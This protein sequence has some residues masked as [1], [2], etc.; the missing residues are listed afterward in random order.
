MGYDVQAIEPNKDAVEILRLKCDYHQLDKQKIFEARA[1]SLPFDGNYFDMVW[2]YT[3]L[4]HVQDIKKSIQEIYRVL[5]P[6]GWAFIATA[7][8]RH[9]YEPHYKIYLPNFLPVFLLKIILKLR[10]KPTQYIGKGINFITTRKVRNILQHMK[11]DSLLMHH[12]WPDEW[13]NHRNFNMH[14]TYW[15]YR[16]TGIPRDQWWFVRKRTD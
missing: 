11:F 2:S 9:F 10:G 4:E 1:E 3:V 7:D 5:K 14:L 8:Y 6:G 16:I 15:L 13:K 12:H